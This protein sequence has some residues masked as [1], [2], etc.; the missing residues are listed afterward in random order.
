MTFAP[1]YGSVR[2]AVGIRVLISCNSG[3]LPTGRINVIAFYGRRQK[4]AASALGVIGSCLLLVAAGQTAEEP[5]AVAPRIQWQRL[6]SQGD[7]TDGNPCL[8]RAEDGGYYVVGISSRRIRPGRFDYSLWIWKLDAHGKR[9]WARVPQI[10]GL[11]ESE[12][13]IWSSCLC[14]E[15]ARV[16]LARESLPK[17]GIWLMRFNPEGEI[18]T[19][20]ALALGRMGHSVGSF[21]SVKGGFLIAGQK[22]NDNRD[23][24]VLKLDE[25]GNTLWQQTYDHGRTEAATALDTRPDGGFVFAANS[26]QYNKFGAGPSEVWAVTCD[27]NGK[28]LAEA[29]F[30]GRHPTIA[31]LTDGSYALTINT[32]DFPALDMQV[33]GLDA[34]LN[35]TWGPHVLFQG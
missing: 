5:P 11:A 21:R 29:T 30:E 4:L 16:I 13:I 12:D 23:A 10:P 34:G 7:W 14:I 22:L 20:K 2:I 32:K 19:C 15:N 26:G 17:T 1:Y 8:V 25:Q 33:L 3:D 31:R 28:I 24:W 6:Y 27:A 18:T 35:K 9:L